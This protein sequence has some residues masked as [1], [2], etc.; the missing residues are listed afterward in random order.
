MTLAFLFQEP[1]YR[2]PGETGKF[3]AGGRE[4][5]T[6]AATP[7]PAERLRSDPDDRG[8]WGLGLGDV[9]GHLRHTSLTTG[10][11]VPGETR[12]GGSA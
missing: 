10:G 3:S 7:L 4:P 8:S 5:L 2:L 6:G 12:G 1:L 11:G 9:G